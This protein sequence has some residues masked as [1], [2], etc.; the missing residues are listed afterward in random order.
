MTHTHTYTP[1]PRITVFMNQQ[2]LLI[3]VIQSDIFN[4][5]LSYSILFYFIKKN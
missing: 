3:H 1:H 2:S 4:S 5:I